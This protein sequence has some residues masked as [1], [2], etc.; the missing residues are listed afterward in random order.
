MIP[1]GHIQMLLSTTL[2]FLCLAMALGSS[3]QFVSVA[4][5]ILGLLSVRATVFIRP[6]VEFWEHDRCAPISER[7]L[8]F[9]RMLD[10]AAQSLPGTSTSV[11]ALRTMCLYVEL[12]ATMFSMLAR[13]G[14]NRLRMPL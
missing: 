3:S 12:G 4:A 13:N 5:I 14:A 6:R 1:A 9:V 2:S 7:F 8:R 10:S 11:V